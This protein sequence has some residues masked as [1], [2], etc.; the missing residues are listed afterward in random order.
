MSPTAVDAA[1]AALS[2][3]RSQRSFDVA[4]AEAAG[5]CY[6]AGCHYMVVL[7]LSDAAIGAYRYSIRILTIYIRI[8]Q[9]HTYKPSTFFYI[10]FK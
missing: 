4:D 1:T 7:L 9:V 3:L 10:S 5:V 6:A 8:Y 2:L